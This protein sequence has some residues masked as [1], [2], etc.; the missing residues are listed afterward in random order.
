MSV[1]GSVG[2][3]SC[4]KSL[5]GGHHLSLGSR[6]PR[7]R[8]M[9]RTTPSLNDTLSLLFIFGGGGSRQGFPVPLEPVLALAL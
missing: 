1:T 5:N 7:A 8:R 3:G 2:F 6:E 9:P 4:S